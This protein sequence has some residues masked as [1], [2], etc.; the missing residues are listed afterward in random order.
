MVSFIRNE[1]DDEGT[2]RCEAYNRVGREI[3]EMTVTFKGIAYFIFTL[4][5]ILKDIIFRQEIN[6]SFVLDTDCGS[7]WYT[8]YS[9]NHF[10]C[11]ERQREGIRLFR[12]LHKRKNY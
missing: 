3:R 4:N 12:N 2:Y 10:M 5:G 6:K 1:A 8:D 7:G 11:Q 9:Y